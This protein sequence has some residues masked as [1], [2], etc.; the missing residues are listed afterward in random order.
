MF[1]QPSYVRFAT[2]S[3]STGK[4]VIGLP[5]FVTN[6]QP[7]DPPA[8]AAFRIAALNGAAGFV[9]IEARTRYLDFEVNARL[10]DYFSPVT[11]G[12][13]L[14]GVRTAY[15]DE[16]LNINSGLRVLPNGAYFFRGNA[17]AEGES[18]RIQDRFSTNN[19]FYG[20]QTGGQWSLDLDRFFLELN[21]KIAVG[22]THQQVRIDGL[23]TLLPNG[24]RP[25]SAVGGLLALP[26]NMGV[27]NR[28]QFSLLP[29]VGVNLGFNVCEW[30]RIKGGYSLSV[31]SDVTR[32]GQAIDRNIDVT[33]PPASPQFGQL[34]AG[35]GSPRLG[36]RD[37]MLWLH[38]FNF[39]VEIHY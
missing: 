6:S 5:V 28:Y 3:D 13:L 32:P 30:M 4:P 35:D 27:H 29:E 10:Q 1:T 24:G 8:E 2:A 26:S 11:R 19:Q 17:L 18:L 31:W 34:P 20:L 15:L 23:T 12:S 16:Y 21:G 38:L 25:T 33:Q 9:N 37:E 22:V 7:D 14:F 36:F 39:G